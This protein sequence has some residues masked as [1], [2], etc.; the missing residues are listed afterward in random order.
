M[1]SVHCL[2]CCQQVVYS[3]V[4][5]NVRVVVKQ[6]K[7]EEKIEWMKWWSVL[8]ERCLRGLRI[9]SLGC[10]SECRKQDEFT[11]RNDYVCDPVTN[12]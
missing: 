12:I 6:Q 3:L 11:L 10:A 5:S 1:L 9:L 4:V 8:D 7:V 2:V